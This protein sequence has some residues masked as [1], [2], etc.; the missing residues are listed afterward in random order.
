MAA[1]ASSAKSRA[2]A[3]AAEDSQRQAL[4]AYQGDWQNQNI[5]EFNPYREGTKE[6]QNFQRQQAQAAK[7]GKLGDLRSDVSKL[8][9]R[10][11]ASDVEAQ[12]VGG[13]R[14]TNQPQPMPGG[15]MSTQV[16]PQ[17]STS[18]GAAGLRNV[19]TTLKYDAAGRPI[20]NDY[21]AITDKDGNLAS[22]QSLAS[23]IGPEVKLNTQGVD[24]IRNRAF[25]TGPSAWATLAEQNQQM[26]EGRAISDSQRS[27]LANQNRAYNALASRGGLSA[28]QRERLATQGMRQGMSQVQNIRG[29]GMAD[30]LN[31]GM[32]DQQKK[33]QFLSQVPG[34]DLQNANFQQG[35][36]A[37][38]AQASQFDIGNQLK[39]IGGLNAYNANAFDAAMKEWGATKS[40]DAQAK[41]AGSGGKK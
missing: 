38:G 35:Q 36:R 1:Q 8:Y 13:L 7:D 34:L 11:Y 37:F 29:Q 25:A 18:Q 5:L 23:R 16:M 9:D 15:Q 32:Q 19:N 41:A 20:R 22:N 12:R 39:D 17:G 26:Q 28:G 21:T 14:N 30:R 4:N 6:Y 2:K 3:Q 24:E 10:F 31:I 27:N 40:A 33:D